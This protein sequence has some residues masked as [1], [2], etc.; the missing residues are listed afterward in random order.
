MSK[1]LQFLLKFDKKEV[2]RGDLEIPEEPED[3][4]EEE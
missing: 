3:I 2:D 1:K 4:E